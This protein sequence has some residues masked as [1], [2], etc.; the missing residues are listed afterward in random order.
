MAFTLQFKTDSDAFTDGEDNFVPGPE[1]ARIL[2]KIAGKF[3]EDL[4]YT[5]DGPA[6]PVRDG[7]GNR[8]G[9]YRL[10]TH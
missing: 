4:G 6:V 2:S 3:D 7:N 10:T 9:S 1:I 5:I 8:I